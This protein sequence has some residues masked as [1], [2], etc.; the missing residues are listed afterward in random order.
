MKARHA[1]RGL[2]FLFLFAAVSKASAGPF[3]VRDSTW[4]GCGE[5]LRLAR[6]KLGAERVLVRGTLDWSE[7]RSQDGILI[8]H[9]SQS[10]DVDEAAEFMKSG[11]RFGLFDDFGEGEKLLMHFRIQRRP[12]PDEPKR[13]LRNNRA[14]AIATPSSER[15]NGQGLSFLHPTVAEVQKVVL[16]HASGLRH[17][18]LTSVLE[19]HPRG[20]G[21][22]VAV[23]VAGQVDKGRF[24]AMGDP[25]VFINLM[26]RYPGNR[27]FA[28]GVIRYLADGDLTQPRRGR[29]F[30]LSNA[31][32]QSGSF[33]GSTPLRK[34]L[35]RKLMALMQAI[36]DLR[37]KGFPWWLH[38]VVAGLCALVLV[39]WLLVQLVRVYRPRIP[40][41]ARREPLLAQEGLAGR[42][43]VLSAPSSPRVLGL[44][45]LQSAL[46]DSLGQALNEGGA[47]SAVELVAMLHSRHSLGPELR[48]Q[49]EDMLALMRTAESAM[50]RGQATRVSR[51]QLQKAEA[52]VLA[53]L[54]HP[55]EQPS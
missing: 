42:L 35:E 14:I 50:Q 44:L 29:L 30:V 40:R 4:Q 11:G 1:L 46:R 38:L 3:E 32:E 13:R 6:E 28:E 7:I 5:L 21:E 37:D 8:L 23:A 36:V 34:S 51:R 43:A 27:A 16:N 12:L 55:R 48:A 9:P 24:F 31:F 54:A 33:G 20:P 25:S 39:R 26:M 52:V 18:D 47:R 19:V 41:F 53:L 10:I 2:A 15:S 45:E 49:T 22:S 17:P